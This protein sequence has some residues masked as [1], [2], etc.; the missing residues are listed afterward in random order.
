MFDQDQKPFRSFT[1][2]IR[3]IKKDRPLKPLPGQLSFLDGVEPVKESQKKRKE[4]PPMTT[5]E[6]NQVSRLGVD[7]D[8]LESDIKKVDHEM[9]ELKRR[10]HE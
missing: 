9:K 4:R 6:W 5:M 1:K 8:H 10:C 3:R 2:R 7:I